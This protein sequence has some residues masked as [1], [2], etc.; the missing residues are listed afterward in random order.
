MYF[1]SSE[2]T[3]FALLQLHRFQDDP[4]QG[5]QPLSAFTQDTPVT[6][7]LTILAI[8]IIIFLKFEEEQRKQKSK[9]VVKQLS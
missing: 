3:A 4:V 7:E 8:I 2:A 1:L 9:S 5:E 6:V